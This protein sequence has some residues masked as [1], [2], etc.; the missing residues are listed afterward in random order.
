[1]KNT[2]GLQIW[3]ISPESIRNDLARGTIL[4]RQIF[5]ENNAQT[6]LEFHVQRPNDANN[7]EFVVLHGYKFILHLKDMKIQTYS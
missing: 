6:P 7:S 3:L 1:M 2:K 4:I 5:N